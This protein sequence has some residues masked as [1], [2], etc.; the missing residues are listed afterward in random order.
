[1][2]N[3]TNE[4]RAAAQR[5]YI[6]QLLWLISAQLNALL[7]G[8]EFPVPDAQTALGAPAAWP[9]KAALLDLL[10]GADP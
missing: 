9:D 7:G 3:P 1:M 4:E 5:A 6:A 10:K 8:G 2:S